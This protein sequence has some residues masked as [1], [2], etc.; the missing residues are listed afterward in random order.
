MFNLIPINM[1][2]VTYSIGRT[3]RTVITETFHKSLM[4]TVILYPD[5]SSEVY[6][7]NSGESML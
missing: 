6:F 4:K 5:R 7:R 1:K 3:G 2:T